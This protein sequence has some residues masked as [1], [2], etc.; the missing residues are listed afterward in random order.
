MNKR[1]VLKIIFYVICVLLVVSYFLFTVYSLDEDYTLL[2]ATRSH[3]YF[4]FA[5]ILPILFAVFDSLKKENIKWF[6]N[7][8]VSC[9]GLILCL[10]MCVKDAV[11]QYG[12][13]ITIACYFVLSI[14]TSL[15]LRK[16]TKIYS[17]QKLAES[18]IE[19]EKAVEELMN[20][21]KFKK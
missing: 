21:D 11:M 6:L 19:N 8:I 13:Y 9:F 5:L 16:Q 15:K 20:S 17:E 10:L 12:W 14:V 18:K 1:I 2:Q 7:V 4:A 3:W